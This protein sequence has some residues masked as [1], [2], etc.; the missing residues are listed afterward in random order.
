MLQ[1]DIIKN[2]FLAYNFNKSIL[3]QSCLSTLISLLIA[4]S[5]MAITNVSIDSPVN[6]TGVWI[7]TWPKWFGLAL[8]TIIL[9]LLPLKP[10]LN[11][12]HRWNLLDGAIVA[13]I[14]WLSI[15][16]LWSIDKGNTII[17]V[18]L[19]GVLIGL[20]V[21]LRR[22][23]LNALLTIL[24]KTVIF[25]VIAIFIS[26]F[27]I[28]GT[29]WTT[30]NENYITELVII[31]LPVIVHFFVVRK[32][33]AI[34]VF[35]LT[36]FIYC[37][38]FL[39][40]KSSSLALIV[41]AGLP[42][43]YAV[44]SPSKQY[45]RAALIATCMIFLLG[46]L[47]LVFYDSIEHFQDVRISIEHRLQIWISSLILLF[48]NPFG[49]IVGIGAGSYSYLYPLVGTDYY[50]FFPALG[51]PKDPK[52]FNPGQ[53]HNEYIQILVETGLIGLML[54]LMIIRLII[55]K[56]S[57]QDNHEYQWIL[58][59]MILL[60]GICVFS[61]P[62]QRGET[63][64]I[65]ILLLAVIAS[66][67]PHQVTWKAQESVYDNYFKPI[68][69]CIG[70]MSLVIT[71]LAGLAWGYFTLFVAAVTQGVAT[72]VVDIAYRGITH[73]PL[74]GPRFDLFHTYIDVQKLEE[75]HKL[76]RGYVDHLYQTSITASPYVPHNMI[77]RLIYLFALG[78]KAEDRPEIEKLLGDV[79]KTFGP[80]YSWPHS[81]NA[82]YAI[83][84]R[85]IESAKL[86]IAKA[87]NAEIID[88]QDRVRLARMAIMLQ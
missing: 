21:Q 48:E 74:L 39:L 33:I 59:S 70:G 69:I 80:L 65:V 40:F 87:Q 45:K 5:I 4:G 18:L 25:V 79:A 58:C 20:Y 32:S 42:I 62:L 78:A 72:H 56:I 28:S 17:T 86:Y 73:W 88:S 75:L 14:A 22:L 2:Y 31:L 84:K 43:F 7:T 35:Y 23:C 46:V 19:S 53:T 30:G 38:Y 57:C 11:E 71:F 54:S 1:T 81:L 37:L 27:T 64:G 66:L 68:F 15:T 82:Q 36:L 63:V 6:S 44:C 51:A 12:Q 10:L 24:E 34:K 60:F 41:I 8:T 61:F 76:D 49:F 47:A 77:T 83:I 67:N 26:D 13:L 52:F 55:K 3:Y 9:F 50:T 16:S 29:H 85:D